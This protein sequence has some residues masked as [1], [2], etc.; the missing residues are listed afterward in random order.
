MQKP[1]TG[2]TLIELLVVI[3][4]IGILLAILTAS[5]TEA[6]QQSRDKIRMSTMKEVELALEVY[7]A[8]NGRYPQMG[9]SA[10]DDSVGGGYW[11]GEF[12]WSVSWQYGCQDYI[13]G[14]AP[15]YILSLPEDIISAQDGR[16]FIYNTNT[17]GTAY[18]FMSHGDVEAITVQSYSNEFARCP[19]S[20]AGHTTT[21]LCRPAG[22]P[23]NIY[24][25]YSPGAECW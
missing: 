11:A 24:A 19:A 23:T 17:L 16:G 2:F 8:Q 21:L 14:L 7:K 6:R 18:K 22:P 4:I 25:I 1:R 5:F 10:P 9:C 13:T 3:S 20:C 15:D 12:Q